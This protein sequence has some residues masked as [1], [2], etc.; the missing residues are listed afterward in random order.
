MLELPDQLT[1]TLKQHGYSLTHA[2]Q[3]VFRAL[4]EREPQTMRELVQAC[5]PGIN[6]ASVYR[7][8]ALYEQLGVMQRLQIG[9]KYKLELTDSFTN[10]HHHL[11]CSQCG[12]VTPLPEDH[13][14]EER[15]TE[16]AQARSFL[17][18][19]HQIEIRGVCSDCQNLK[20]R[21][22]NRPDR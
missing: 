14:L 20:I 22:E 5:Q 11:T 21:H 15:L 4:Q 16:L 10:H 13:Q 19:A 3:A 2:R 1:G 7:T 17:P 9:W 12:Q 18:Q 6:R 8:V